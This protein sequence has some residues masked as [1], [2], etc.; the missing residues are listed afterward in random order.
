[1]EAM[2]A[3]LHLV[4]VA[5]NVFINHRVCDLKREGLGPS[6]FYSKMGAS[7]FVDSLVNP[8]HGNKSSQSL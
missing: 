5:K 6:L 1:M 2:V 8:R 3:A 4:A 7:A